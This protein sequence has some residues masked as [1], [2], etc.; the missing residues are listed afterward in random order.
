MSFISMLEIAVDPAAST[1]DAIF[2]HD[3]PHTAAFPGNESTEVLQDSQDPSRLTVMTRWS[4]QSDMDAYKAWRQTPEGQTRLREI[5][6]GPAVS[7]HFGVR[8]TF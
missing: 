1:L 6:T 7:R 5:V 2:E 3:L 8:N 4:T